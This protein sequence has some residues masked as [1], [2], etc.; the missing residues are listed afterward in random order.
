MGKKARLKR[1]RR[2]AP[3]LVQPPENVVAALEEAS[4]SDRAWFELHPEESYRTRPA[5]DGEFWPMVQTAIPLY[6]LVVQVRPGYRL[7]CPVLRLHPPET[8]R[9]Q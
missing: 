5:V 2:A 4:A 1:E 8:E 6:V 7:R 3:R 9:L